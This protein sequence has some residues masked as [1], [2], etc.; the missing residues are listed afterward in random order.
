MP[1][2]LKQGELLVSSRSIDQDAYQQ[3]L[4][5]KALY[6]ERGRANIDNAI[7]LLDEIVARN[8]DYAP[9]WALLAESHSIIPN[10]ANIIRLSTDE[11]RALVQS[12][13][14]KAD[15]AARKAIQL[16][17]NLADGYLAL[18]NV[19]L[20]DGKFQTAEEFF[21]KALALDPNDPEVLSN[22]SLMLGFVGHVKE[23]AAMARQLDAV[24]PFIPIFTRN[25]GVLLWVNGEDEA[26]IAKLKTV[27][28]GGPLIAMIQA[29]AGHYK[30]AADTLAPL[31]GGQ[32]DETMEAVRLLR[33]APQP[34]PA[35][36]SVRALG[37]LDFV[38]LHT[39]APGQFLEAYEAE[40][41]SGFMASFR[42][43]LFWHPS[44]A[45]VRKT[46]RFKAFVRADGLV[47][48]WKAKGWPPQCHATTGDDFEC[49]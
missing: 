34:V 24:E 14:S 42:H 38:Y 25:I 48:Y 4:R 39:G 15:V 47:D 6:R 30:E 19:Y 40:I 1:L 31:K 16:D 41:R 37:G 35:P 26:A 44:I 33:G 17:P 10:Y 9:A 32:P 27:P 45:S 28:G 46:D 2:G 21:S 22:Y 49:N 3:Y 36:Q 11:A 7:A 29:A 43:A 5:A 13:R 18:G 12:T 20:R 23:A 8:P